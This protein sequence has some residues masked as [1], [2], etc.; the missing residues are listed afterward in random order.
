MTKY[1]LIE[2]YADDWV[3]D[4]YGTYKKWG[5]VHY[6]LGYSDFDRAMQR[7][8]LIMR[9]AQTFNKNYYINSEPGRIYITLTAEN[10]TNLR[11]IN[12]YGS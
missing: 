1:K 11:I 2:V 12:I 8:E 9:T 7:V 6:R 5:R 3:R 4:E 10:S